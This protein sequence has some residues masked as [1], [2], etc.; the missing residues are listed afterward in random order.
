MAEKEK[1]LSTQEAKVGADLQMKARRQQLEADF[2]GA[3][4][5]SAPAVPAGGVGATPY[6][7]S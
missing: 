5:P 4:G 2:R 6:A 3:A 7:G 1:N